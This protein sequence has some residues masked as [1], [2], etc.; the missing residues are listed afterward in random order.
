[1]T[2]SKPQQ[3]WHT[4]LGEIGGGAGGGFGAYYNLYMFYIYV[5][6]HT[7]WVKMVVHVVVHQC[8]MEVPS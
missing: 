3:V 1:M 7:K 2:Y 5:F 6:G 8:D 4:Q